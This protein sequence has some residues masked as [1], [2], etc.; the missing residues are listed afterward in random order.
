MQIAAEDLNTIK[1]IID[2]K[3]NDEEDNTKSNRNLENV[4]IEINN[5]TVKPESVSITIT[6]NNENQYGQGVEFRVQEKVD[7]EWKNLN[8]IF[9]ELSWIDIAYELN[10]DDSENVYDISIKII[11]E[12]IKNK[13]K[14]PFK[15]QNQF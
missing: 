11:T 4:M 1:S 2:N 9:D 10:E 6:Y 7:G 15:N 5:S 12:E 3:I 8:Y 14:H 13:L